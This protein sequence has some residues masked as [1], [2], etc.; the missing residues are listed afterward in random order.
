MRHSDMR[1]TAKVY[2]DA[3]SLPVGKAMLRLPDSHVLVPAF[4]KGVPNSRSVETIALQ[5][6][7]CEQ[8]AAKMSGVVPNSFKGNGA[9]CRLRPCDFISSTTPPACDLWERGTGPSGQ[10]TSPASIPKSQS[11]SKLL[12][13]LHT[14]HKSARHGG[15]FI[16]CKRPGVP[17]A[18][19]APGADL[20]RGA[21]FRCKLH[22]QLPGLLLCPGVELGHSQQIQ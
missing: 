18:A 20:S 6:P 4:L 12:K 13:V 7:D 5:F 19:C 14:A 17:C 1:L 3:G 11:D 2:T 22:G 10:K 15:T 21:D 9:R 8:Q 16:K